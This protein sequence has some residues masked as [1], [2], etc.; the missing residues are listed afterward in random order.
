MVATH[1]DTTRCIGRTL[2]WCQ[3]ANS[4]LSTL[5]SW[6]TTVMLIHRCLLLRNLYLR[7]LHKWI[8]GKLPN[9]DKK[10]VR[11]STVAPKWRKLK[12]SWR[13]T[14]RKKSIFGSSNADWGFHLGAQRSKETRKTLQRGTFRIVQANSAS[15]KENCDESWVLLWVRCRPKTA[16]RVNGKKRKNEKK[17]ESKALQLKTKSKRVISQTTHKLSLSLRRGNKKLSKS[18][19]RSSKSRRLSHDRNSQYRTIM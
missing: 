5:A 10:K 11:M 15:W 3:A 14:T 7:V 4:L 1:T 8:L 9:K 13:Q 2:I 18:L 6:S 12:K 16:N 17:N 19:S